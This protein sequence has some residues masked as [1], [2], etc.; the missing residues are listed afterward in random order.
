MPRTM[1]I[2]KV[3][4]SAFANVDEESDVLATS[5]SPNPIR[6]QESNNA[7]CM[8]MKRR[9]KKKEIN[10]RERKNLLFEMLVTSTQFLVHATHSLRAE[11]IAAE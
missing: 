5:E 11:Y 4:N 8:K 9:G 6:N 2:V 7:L 3:E 10:K 1:M